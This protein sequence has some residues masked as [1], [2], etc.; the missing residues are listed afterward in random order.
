[1]SLRVNATF[2]LGAILLLIAFAIQHRGISGT[3]KMQVVLGLV[4]LLPLVLIGTVPLL[5]GDVALTNLFPLTPLA[6][7]AAGRVV[8]GHWGHG[9]GG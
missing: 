9:R 3:A 7:D 2:V 4:A 8:E 1:M 6:K 5:S